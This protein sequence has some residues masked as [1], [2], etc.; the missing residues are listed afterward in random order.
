[1]AYH[2]YIAAFQ[3]FDNRIIEIDQQKEQINHYTI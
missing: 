2:A 3:L 1:M